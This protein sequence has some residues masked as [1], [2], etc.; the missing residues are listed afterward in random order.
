MQLRG[1]RTALPQ[2]IVSSGGSAGGYLAAAV[3]TID[4]FHS[5]GDD[6]C[7]SPKPNAMVLFNPVV[8]FVTTERDD[9][10]PW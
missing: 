2:R 10:L 1:S 7:V 3:A 4:G 9:Y 8:D 5:E 6:L